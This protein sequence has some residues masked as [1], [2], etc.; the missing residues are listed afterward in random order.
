MKSRY[1]IITA[2]L[3]SGV[4]SSTN[5]ISN[6]GW[7][8][9]SDVGAYTLLGSALILPVTRDDWQGFRQ[10]GYS[11]VTAEGVALLGKA[12]VHEERP[13]NSDNNSFPSGHSSLAFA[14]ATTMYL[15]YGWQAGMP[16]YALATLT[17]GTRVAARKHF[18][19]DVVAGAAI[20]SASAWLFTDAFND[21][22]QL[23]PWIDTDGKGGGLDLTMRW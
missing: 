13:D 3:M 15:R 17:A 16:A 18:V 14:S 9:I 20:G 22:V 23:N 10:A 12:V 11:I 21:K 7:A 4:S 6:D 1:P 2:L 8:N 5:A 19:W